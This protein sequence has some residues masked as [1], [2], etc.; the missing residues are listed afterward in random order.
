MHVYSD[1]IEK[2]DEIIFP[3]KCK[4]GFIGCYYTKDMSVIEMKEDGKSFTFSESNG[5]TKYSIP[6]TKKSIP[7]GRKKW[8]LNARNETIDLV[9]TPCSEVRKFVYRKYY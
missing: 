9:I 8:L 6:I 4:S 1:N 2:K 7:L 5:A 3:G